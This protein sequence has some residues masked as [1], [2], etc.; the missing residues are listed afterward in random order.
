MFQ[1]YTLTLGLGPN[2]DIAYFW[3]RAAARCNHGRFNTFSR[4]NSGVTTQSPQFLNYGGPNTRNFGRTYISSALPK[5]VSD[6]KYVACFRN[7][8]SALNGRINKVKFRIFIHLKIGRGV[9][10]KCVL[11]LQESQSSASSWMC[12]IIDILFSVNATM[13]R[14]EENLA[15]FDPPPL[16]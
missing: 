4:P 6:I 1:C 7:Y 14:L 9:S 11:Q 8:Q 2:L 13:S 16:M 15:L 12:Q 3:G 10:A 5:F